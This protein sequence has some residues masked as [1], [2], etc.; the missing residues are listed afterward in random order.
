[1]PPPNKLSRMAPLLKYWL[2]WD[3]YRS[4][5]AGLYNIEETTERHVGRIDLHLFCSQT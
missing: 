4:I 3:N 2:L 1:M 5:K